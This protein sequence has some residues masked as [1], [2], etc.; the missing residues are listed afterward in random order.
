MPEE[1]GKYTPQK[2]H[3]SEKKQLRVWLSAEKF[4]RFKKTVT[5]K[6]DSIYGL[7]NKFVDVYLEKNEE[8]F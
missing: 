8:K 1:K 7:I 5:A 2:K 6:G 3:L 4:D